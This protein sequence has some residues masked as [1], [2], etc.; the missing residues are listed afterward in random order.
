MVQRLT[1]PIA[2]HILDAAAEDQAI[3][4]VLPAV[5]RV[6]DQPT[7]IV[8]QRLDA[9][10]P[11]AVG[12]LHLDLFGH[13]RIIHDPIKRNLDRASR[14][15]RR[16]SHLPMGFQERL[17][18]GR[19]DVE[20]FG[21]DSA[22][23]PDVETVRSSRSQRW[24]VRWVGPHAPFDAPGLHE[25]GQAPSVRRPQFVAQQEKGIRYEQALSGDQL[26]L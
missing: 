7:T 9:G 14:S 22:A 19:E 18:C 24:L 11:K 8:A 6:E 17:H 10:E 16:P 23:S 25:N 21:K 1:K 3:L 2:A 13:D 5:N 12:T 26:Q 15:D 20:D 4:G